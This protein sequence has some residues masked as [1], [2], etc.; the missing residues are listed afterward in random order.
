[1]MWL[2]I[3]LWLVASPKRSLQSATCAGVCVALAVLSKETVLVTLPGVVVLLWDRRDE[4]NARMRDIHF[5]AMLVLT[6]LVYPLYAIIKSELV[7]GP[8]HVSLWES[9]VW[10]LHGRKGSGSLLDAHST[11]HA[12]VQSWLHIDPFLLGAGV[13]LIPVALGVKRLRAIAV[14]LIIQVLVLFRGGYLPFA[15]ATALFPF[16]ALIIAGVG[17]RLWTG[18][19]SRRG[20]TSPRRVRWSQP[21]V[22]GATRVV[23]IA[24]VAAMTVLVLPKHWGPDLRQAMAAQPNLATAEAT[25]YVR[26]HLPHNA[27]LVADD[28]V[29][30]DLKLQGWTAIP[31]FKLDLD[32][33]IHSQ[34]TRGYRSIDY[35]LL[36]PTDP[37]QLEAEGL[38]TVATAL[39]HSEAVASFG[40]GSLTL[41][42][43]VDTAVTDN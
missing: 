4:R 17:D 12:A 32:P 8:G 10:Q 31:T 42:K 11:T 39:R 40:N 5:W 16:A 29:W 6:M 19:Q 13:L 7:P 28:D 37:A 9:L 38:P 26:T 34:L 24:A 2:I 18:W 23:V 30:T 22:T 43:V 25:E 15:Y 33:A 35:L 36:T 1:V 41:R 21:V 14:C 27:L 3:A 20:Q